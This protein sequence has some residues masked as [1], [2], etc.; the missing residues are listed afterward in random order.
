[1]VRGCR[2][3]QALARINF[4]HKRI[5]IIFIPLIHTM[6]GFATAAK[7]CTNL[8][9]CAGLDLIVVQTQERHFVAFLLH[10]L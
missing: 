2:Q 4:R 1:M 5:E 10:G 7:P 3:D 9:A 8:T 6:N